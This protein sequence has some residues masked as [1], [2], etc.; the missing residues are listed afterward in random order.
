MQLDRSPKENVTDVTVTGTEILLC[1]FYAEIPSCTLGSIFLQAFFAY[2]AYEVKHRMHSG[3]KLADTKAST[4][5]FPVPICLT[6]V[7]PVGHESF[8][9]A[10]ILFSGD[11][12]W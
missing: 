7:V 9:P 11:L 3:F 4:D 8:S 2:V 6:F 1:P 12:H 10:W 5:P